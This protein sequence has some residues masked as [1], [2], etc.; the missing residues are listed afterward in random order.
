[1]PNNS[2]NIY[3]VLGEHSGD[4]LG[5]DLYPALQMR[6]AENGFELEITGLVGPRLM[7]LGV[8]S[9][10][11]IEDISVMGISAILGRLPMIIKR[12]RQTVDD[13]ETTKPDLLVLI[14]SPEFTHA[15]AKRVRRK[16]PD[17]PVINYIC[18][19]VWAW[20]AGRAK[21][22]RAYIDHVLAIL[23]FEPRVLADLGGPPATY[24]GHPLARQVA[25]MH[26]SPV[27]LPLP[28]KGEGKP[29]LLVLPGSRSSELKRMLNRFGK[30]LEV[31]RKRS[32]DFHPIIPAVPHLKSML[33]DQTAKWPVKV[34]IVDSAD[35]DWNFSRAHAALATSG[36]VALQL[37]L[38][39]VP[40]VT[41]YRLDPVARPFGSLVKT[42]SVL[43]PNLI[44]DRVVVPEEVNE[45]VMP[46]RMARHLERL[47]TD[48]PERR[49]QLQGFKEIIA[50]MKTKRPP[51]NG[52]P[53]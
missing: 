39:Q 48:T 31:L 52:R 49:A 38:H 20:R 25:S 1:M 7:E 33:L 21:K 42:W 18:P 8:S 29:V 15:V 27:P 6:A 44:A 45:T 43:L 14:D 17:L 34:E 4:E 13:I 10:F 28:G 35:N 16:L 24:V 46:E 51:V 32:V 36:T 50:L 53:K 11:D 30:T 5:A 47:L 2:K 12:V 3:F 23:P 22:M 9:L 40:M 26:A 37:A 41:G 19:S